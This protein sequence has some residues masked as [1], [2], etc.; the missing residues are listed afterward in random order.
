MKKLLTAAAVLLGI[1]VFAGAGFL[2]GFIKLGSPFETDRYNDPTPEEKKSLECKI[3]IVN[4]TWSMLGDDIET[5]E[6]M[7]VVSSIYTGCE[8]PNCPSP[9]KVSKVQDDRII[10]KTSGY[11]QDPKSELKKGEIVHLD[12]SSNVAEADNVNGQSVFIIWKE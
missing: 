11:K 2:L 7:E 5:D 10:L 4:S 6:S 3:E 8:L 1:V 12:C 9:V